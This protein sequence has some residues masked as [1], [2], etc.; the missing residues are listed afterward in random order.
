MDAALRMAA[1]AGN[2]AHIQYALPRALIIPAVFFLDFTGG[3]AAWLVKFASIGVDDIGENGVQRRFWFR[4]RVSGRSRGRFGWLHGFFCGRLCRR[5][6]R[7]FC[8][9]RLCGRFCWFFGW[10]LRGC[11]RGCSCWTGRR[12]RLC[13][14]LCFRLRYGKRGRKR[15]FLGRI[16]EATKQ[17]MSIKRAHPP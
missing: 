17:T 15:M 9:W 4:R 13:G 16:F 7:L 8:G 1:S 12:R 6:C 5:R 3:S 11:F 10:R 14:G 2:V